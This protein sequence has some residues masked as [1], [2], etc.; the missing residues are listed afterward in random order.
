MRI[1]KIIATICSAAILCTG[2]VFAAPE[3]EIIED[4]AIELF[5]A[6]IFD[7]GTG[8]ETDP[9]LISKEEQLMLVADLPSASFKLTSNIEL[10]NDWN[11]IGKDGDNFSGVFDGDG[12]CISGLTEQF[13]YENKGTVKNT[14]FKTIKE[15]ISSSAVVAYDNKGTIESCYA[16]GKVNGYRYVE[17]FIY[18]NNGTI[19]N[20]Y[21]KGNVNSINGNAGG[22]VGYNDKTIKNCY[23]VATVDAY[24]SK[25]G[26]AYS[27]GSTIT[28]CYY[29]KQISGLSDTGDGE[30][31]NTL[32]LK[33]AATYSGWDFENV[34]DLDSEINDGYPHHRID[35]RAKPAINSLQLNITEA[36]LIIGETLELTASADPEGADVTVNWQSSDASVA[37]VDASGVVTANAIGAAV[38]TASVG[39]VKAYCSV[40]VSDNS[41]KV[42]SVTLDKSDAG[43]IIG[44]TLKLSA[45]VLPSDATNKNIKWSSSNS[46]VAS[47][48]ADGTVTGISEGETK[49][50]A[51]SV[52]NASCYG[53][54]NI[55][56]AKQKIAVSGIEISGN[57]FGGYEVNIGKTLTLSPV[58][59]PSDATNKDVRWTSSD[60]NVAT[61]INGK[62]TGVSEGSVTIT[63]TT[64][65]GGYTTSVI[66]KVTKPTVYVTGIALNTEQMTVKVKETKKLTAAVT[67]LD[68][69]DKGVIFKSNN[70][71]IANVSADGTVTGVSP[72]T[73]MIQATDSTGMFRAFCTVTV[74]KP[75][76]EVTSVKLDKSS[77]EIVEGK[78][79]P[80]KTIIKPTNATYKTITWSASN[81]SVVTVSQDGFVTACG[82]G[83]AVVS[84]TAVNG[85]NV[86]CN[87]TVLS[88]DTPAQLKVEDATVKA[89]KQ[90]PV[91]VSIASNPGISTF[92]FDL[93]YDNTKMYPVSY[94]KGDALNNVNIVTPLGSQ[95]FKDR[96]SVRFLCQTTDSRNMYSDGDLITVVFQT[97]PDAEYGEHTI[98]IVPSAFT[99]QNYETVNLQSDNCVL[100]ITDY[101]IGDISDDD[102]VDLK[103]SMIFGQYL[104]GFGTEL[105][106]QGKK[107]AVSIY[108]DQND[109]VETS[110]P[111][112]ND[113]QH[114]FRYL[115]DWQVEL[116]KN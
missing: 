14:G 111:T 109:N 94:T 82:V 76:V 114:L 97:L 87:I 68:A 79:V 65:D 42:E 74:P 37:S 103:D 40:T 44:E 104:A 3:T 38:I 96:N 92:N 13:F 35:K 93:T 8:T 52:S 46:K 56:V 58:I 32:A 70:N 29:D 27:N 50:Y 34:W 60:S 105:T 64:V 107:A 47:V 112:I 43:I 83:S 28:N 73:T 99:N 39:T 55:T 30:P 24:Y 81:E 18:T 67:P 51:T 116:G 90:I 72:G 25:S 86:I 66:V 26:F 9:Y 15:G 95:S 61:V 53:V 98:G 62:V 54:C 106:P 85:V 22:F 21:F 49:I 1:K 115:S 89:G 16:E 48:S 77:L 80:L 6:Q 63:A 4:G 45:N 88:S 7:G 100:K 20:C 84:A 110:E 23:C 36:P 2:T 33:M 75:V 57:I 108:P 10:A 78:T 12:Y 113:F 91:T 71:A 5:A 102:V 69:T 101:T 41:V 19:E 59:K 17:G 11:Y 31:K